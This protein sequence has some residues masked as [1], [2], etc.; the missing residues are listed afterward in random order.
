MIGGFTP[1]PLV[2]HDQDSLNKEMQHFEA[3]KSNRSFIFN[4]NNTRSYSLKDNSKAVLYRKDCIGPAFGIDL[5]I[6]KQ[7]TS[8]MGNSY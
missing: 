6:D 5:I 7:V 2:H 1:V 8:S 3:D 4:L